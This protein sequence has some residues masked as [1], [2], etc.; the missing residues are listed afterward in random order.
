MVEWR[1]IVTISLDGDDTSANRNRIVSC[2]ENR[3]FRGTKTG[4]YEARGPASDIGL[5]LRLTLAE[6]DHAALDHLWIYVDRVVDE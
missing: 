6:L 2:L 5:A 1:A 3:G 4:T